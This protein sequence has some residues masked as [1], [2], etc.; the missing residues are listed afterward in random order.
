MAIELVEKMELIPGSCFVCLQ[1]PF[2]KDKDE[3]RETPDPALD[4][5]VDINFGDQAYLCLNCARVVAE[6]LDFISPEQ[7]KEIKEENEDLKA[8]MSE[9]A[10]EHK[11]LQSRVKQILEG[12]K[13]R[14]QVT[15][16]LKDKPVKREKV[17]G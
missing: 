3:D 2:S 1:T 5:G 17:N 16:E 10:E 7:W 14:A 4:M 6:V 13:A 12:K 8:K 9:L 11:A 15:K